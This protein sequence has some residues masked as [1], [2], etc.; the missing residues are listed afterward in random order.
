MVSF[1]P[2]G[3]QGLKFAHCIAR[4]GNQRNPFVSEVH[5]RQHDG[6]AECVHIAAAVRV[7]G[8]MRV[9]A[10]QQECLDLIVEAVMRAVDQNG[11][12]VPQGAFRCFLRRFSC[13][14][15]RCERFQLWCG[16]APA[17]VFPLR[18]TC[19]TSALIPTAKTARIQTRTTHARQ[20]PFSISVPPVPAGLSHFRE[21]VDL[22]YAAWSYSSPM[23]SSTAGCTSSSTPI[24][25]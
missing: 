17:D 23:V 10:E 22:E 19:S 1:R 12:V 18:Y 11:R 15:C 24:T 2:V 5:G 14:R 20:R 13:L 9:D 4:N 21:T 25:R 3:V 7:S 6:V 8:Y 16:V